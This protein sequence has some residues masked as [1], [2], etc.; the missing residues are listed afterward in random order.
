MTIIKCKMCGGDIVL[1]EDKTFGFCEYCGSGM[2]LPRVDSEQRAAVFN[3]GNYFRRIG[4]FDKALAVYEKIVSEDEQDAEAHWC[5]ALCR[6]GIEYVED[7]NTM[8]WFPTCH[9][10]SFDR[11]LEDVDYKAAVEHSEGITRRQYI[12][13]GLKI[14]EVQKG[15]LLTSQNTQPYDIFLCYKESDEKGN[16]TRDS[17]LAQEIYY[18]LTEQGRSVFYSRITLEDVLGTE[19]EP[20]IFAALNSAKV[21]IVVG[22]KPEYLNAPWVKNEWSRFLTLMKKDRSKLM[23]PCYRDMDPYDLPEQLSVLQSYDMSRI[24]FLPDLTRG[25]AKV[26]DS[27]KP[28]QKETV[29]LQ[30]TAANKAPLLKR[31]FLFLEDG[32]WK[33]A[34]EYCEKVLDMDPEDAE[35][36]LG[37]LLAEYKI[38][39]K[40]LLGQSA[41]PFIDNANYQKALRYGDDSVKKFL[42]SARKDV[43]Y[44]AVKRKLSDTP[45]EKQGKAFLKAMVTDLEALSGWRDA[46]AL[47]GS[48]RE[49]LREMEAREEARRQEKRLQAERQQ[50]EAERKTRKAKKTMGILIPTVCAVVAVV[51][52]LNSVVIPLLQNAGPKAT[53]K[54]NESVS[55]SEETVPV[56][57]TEPEDPMEVAYTQ[58]V[59]WEADGQLGRAAIAFGKLGDYSDARQRSLAL[60]N[61][62]TVSAGLHHVVA[63]KKDGTVVAA[64]DD[65]FGQDQCQVED[66]KDI[67][68][69]DATTWFTAG[70]K[71]DGTVVVTDSEERDF[72]EAVSHWEDIAQISAMQNSIVGLKT[73]GTIVQAKWENGAAVGSLNEELGQWSDIAVIRVC[74]ASQFAGVGNAEPAIAGLRTDGTVLLHGFHEAIEQE[75]SQWRD[76]VSIHA[77]GYGIC[78][79]K[80]DGTIVASYLNQNTENAVSKWF[81]IVDIDSSNVEG[82]VYV[83]GI[84]SDGRVAAWG[85]RRGLD[86]AELWTDIVAV[87]VG[88]TAAQTSRRPIIGLKTDGTV[89][90]TGRNNIDQYDLSAFTDIRLPN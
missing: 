5:C 13:E 11:F 59:A 51:L 61:G 82:G 10:V 53:E 28:A 71:S 34:D 24:G 35:A 27:N 64:G 78:G 52:L 54:E 57:V 23:L 39:K 7:P 30:Q 3:R 67:V 75:V 62:N 88:D 17:L 83:I 63:I 2:T 36:Y 85:D 16:R 80:A 73:D 81:E 69:V 26:L 38:R 55:I 49:Q 19:Y 29:I 65:R 4:E 33:T 6:F 18:Q 31:A 1:S 87:D 50:K 8:E 20:Y 46:D 79:Q 44:Y 72:R 68:S 21:M 15:I 40:E 45:A 58:A 9:R 76:I 60:W 47:A 42:D 56:A 43:A 66:W 77:A 41:A 14:A 74:G 37:K 22:T 32:D 84:K 89:V 48:C 70:L 90:V 86:G 12:K 25:I